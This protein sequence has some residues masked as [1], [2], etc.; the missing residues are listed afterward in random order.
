MNLKTRIER[1]QEQLRTQDEPGAV[2][3]IFPGDAVPESGRY[4]LINVVDAS[5]GGERHEP[6]KTH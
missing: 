1:L 5:Q 3:V 2:P 4:I 6:E